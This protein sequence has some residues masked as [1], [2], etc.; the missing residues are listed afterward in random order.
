MSGGRV[1]SRCLAHKQE[2]G[3]NSGCVQGLKEKIYVGLKKKIYAYGFDSQLYM[4]IPGFLQRTG[5]FLVSARM[6][7]EYTPVYASISRCT[8]TGAKNRFDFTLALR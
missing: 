3:V 1:S 6:I 4:P 8:H 2:N 5:R 7:P